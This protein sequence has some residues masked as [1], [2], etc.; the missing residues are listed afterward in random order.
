MHVNHTAHQ[1]QLRRWLCEL[2]RTERVLQPFLPCVWCS[3]S[4]KPRSELQA[5]GRP[6]ARGPREARGAQ[7]SPASSRTNTSME[8]AHATCEGPRTPD[9]GQKR[10]LEHRKSDLHRGLPSPW[11]F[12]A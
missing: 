3:A 8:P 12:H 10:L 2:S 6:R 4:Q 7:G 5:G 9:P 1:S 11:D